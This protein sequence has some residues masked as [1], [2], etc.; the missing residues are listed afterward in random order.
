MCN[1]YEIIGFNCSST[2]V[3]RIS[4]DIVIKFKNEMGQ[5]A[6]LQSWVFSFVWNLWMF[7]LILYY[8][9]WHVYQADLIISCLMMVVL[10]SHKFFLWL[11]AKTSS[12]LNQ[13]F[14]KIKLTCI[15]SLILT[16]YPCK[17]FCTNSFWN[18]C[19]KSI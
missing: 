1:M 9:V 11:S 2:I 12:R 15:R 13:S 6:Q 14:T 19:D 3:K 18:N 4:F 17:H 8:L 5:A 10:E 7:C 16:R